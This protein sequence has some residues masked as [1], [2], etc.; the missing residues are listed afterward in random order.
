MHNQ[1]I[2]RLQQI[3]TDENII[4]LY[5]CESGSRA[6]GFPSADSDY[7]IRF[8]YVHLMEWYLTVQ[9][10][11]DVL[12]FPINENLD[13]SGW[14]I[15]KT[16]GLFR[17]S[18]PPLLEWLG[19]P[20]VYQ[21]KGNFANRL[22]ELSKEYYSPTSCI[23]H[24][25]HMAQGNFKDYVRGED[26]RLKKYFYLLRPIL[27]IKWIEQGYGVAP[28]KFSTLLE[29][30]VTDSTLKEEINHLMKLK[31]TGSETDRGQHVPIINQFI[32]AELSRLE[33]QIKDYQNNPAPFEL[34]DEIFRSTLKIAWG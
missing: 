2:E 27:A 20:I 16:L 9:E 19:S 25:L 24:Y 10:K 8:I 4:I 1:I 30:V 21:E 7:D 6:W 12:E 31:E 26:I 33:I 13:F 15:R 11:R 3:E 18:N 32:E 17:K 5:A 23:Y 34:L 14:D 22:R 29:H 28:T